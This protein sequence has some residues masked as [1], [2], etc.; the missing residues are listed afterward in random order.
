MGL[1]EMGWIEFGNV[2]KDRRGVVLARLA[3]KRQIIEVI[4]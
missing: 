4:H 3:P 1:D 2:G